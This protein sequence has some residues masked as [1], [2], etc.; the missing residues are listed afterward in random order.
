MTTGTLLKRRSD[1]THCAHLA[2]CGDDCALSSLPHTI[3][4]CKDPH[5]DEC[6]GG[7]THADALVAR[8]KAA[9]ERADLAARA[10]MGGLDG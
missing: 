10:G 5:C 1:N 2:P 8:R 3:H 4:G 7:K 6:H 9:A